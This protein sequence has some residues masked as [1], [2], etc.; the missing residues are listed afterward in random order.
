[1]N[2]D[3][4]LCW[5]NTIKSMQSIKCASYQWKTFWVPQIQRWGVWSVAVWSCEMCTKLLIAYMRRTGNWRVQIEIDIKLPFQ[6]MHIVYSVNSLWPSEVLWNSVRCWSKYKFIFIQKCCKQNDNSDLNV[7]RSTLITMQ[8]HKDS[9]PIRKAIRR[10]I[11][12]RR[13]R[14]AAETPIKFQSD[15]TTLKP[16]LAALRFHKIW[17]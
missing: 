14:T 8:W 7:L 10:A 16:Y 5:E 3:V 9:E 2:P 17:W 1:M 4:E 15:Q 13:G 12:M 6:I 11:D